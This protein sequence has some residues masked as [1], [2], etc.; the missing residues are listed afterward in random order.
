MFD[1]GTKRRSVLR[2]KDSIPY[3]LSAQEKIFRAQRKARCNGRVAKTFKCEPG[4][5]PRNK[6]KSNSLKYLYDI[7]TKG[8]GYI[9]LR[10][11]ICAVIL[12]TIVQN[13]LTSTVISGS[14]TLG[15]SVGK[16]LKLLLEIALL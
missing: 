9:R 11:I 15:F 13:I 1:S 10:R 2:V 16:N 3:F 8:I 14:L 12:L 4:S 7:A 6:K 5:C